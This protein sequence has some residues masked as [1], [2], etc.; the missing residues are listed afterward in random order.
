[1]RVAE[2]RAPS[3]NSSCAASSCGVPLLA[4]DIPKARE[5]A[6]VKRCLPLARKALLASK[7]LRVREGGS[8]L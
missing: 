8:K 5:L 4:A 2:E 1:M 3:P 7:G 6:P